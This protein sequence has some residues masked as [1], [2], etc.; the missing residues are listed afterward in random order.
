MWKG[1]ERF[2]VNYLNYSLLYGPSPHQGLCLRLPSLAVAQMVR[3]HTETYPANGKWRLSSPLRLAFPTSKQGSKLL[4]GKISNSHRFRSWIGFLIA[5]DWV[6]CQLHV[7]QS[8]Q[9]SIED[10]ERKLEKLETACGPPVNLIMLQVHLVQNWCTEDSFKYKAKCW[11]ITVIHKASV[12]I[13][14]PNKL[15][16]W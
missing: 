5:W 6:I 16:Q 4:Q 9:V 14:I 2:I 8:L 13:W 11:Y 7:D 1:K 12:F 10:L 15:E 3:S